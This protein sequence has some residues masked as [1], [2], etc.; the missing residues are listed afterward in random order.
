[1]IKFLKRLLC[2]HSWYYKTIRDNEWDEKEKCFI[3]E[4]KPY[5]RKCGVS[6]NDIIW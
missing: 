2:H 4:A 3:T 1:M 5:C 6:A